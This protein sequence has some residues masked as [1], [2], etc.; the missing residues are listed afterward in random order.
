[1]QVVLFAITS[2]GYAFLNAFLESSRGLV[3]FVV[4]ARDSAID[5]DCYERIHN[6][7]SECE[8]LFYNRGSHPLISITG[9]GDLRPSLPESVTS[10]TS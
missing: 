5:A 4:G 7:C 1:M 6:V 10:P 3:A 2:K 9:L 8:I